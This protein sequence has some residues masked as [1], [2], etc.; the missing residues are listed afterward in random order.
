MTFKSRLKKLFDSLRRLRRQSP[1]VLWQFGLGVRDVMA[2][3]LSRAMTGELS[4]AEARLMVEE[5][6]A[7]AVRAMFAYTD[8]ILK[9]KAASA[10]GAYFD[11][12]QR[13]VDFNRKRFSKRRWRV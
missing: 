11:V 13:A 2:A 6:R 7:A 9:G 3:R 10:L 4:A 1:P 5:K 8:S 12:Y